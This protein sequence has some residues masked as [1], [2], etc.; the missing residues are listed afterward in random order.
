MLHRLVALLIVTFSFVPARIAQPAPL[1]PPDKIAQI[2]R[3]TNGAARI[4]RH[5]QTGQV[6]FIGG[7]LDRPIAPPPMGMASARPE[8][9]AQ[10]FVQQYGSLFGAPNAADLRVERTTQADRGRAFVRFG[11]T[12]NGVPV[13]G[14]EL[15]VQTDARGATISASGELAPN[16]NLS[17]TP[18][19]TATTAQIRAV[20]EIARQR[21]VPG[22]RLAAAPPQLAIFDAALL[23]GPPLPRPVL[24]WRTEVTSIDGGLREWVLIDALR[25]VVAL[26]FD[27]QAG[28]L[29]RYVCDNG[30]VPR[31]SD[32]C[33]AAGAERSEGGP[34][35]D[36]PQVNRA[37]EYMGVTYE[38]WRS[39][40]NRDSFDGAGA[41]LVATVR[42]CAVNA[43]CPDRKLVAYWNG[44]QAVFVDDAVVDDFVAHELTH[45]LIQHTARLYNYYQ[46]GAISESLADVFGELIDQSY[47]GAFDTDTADVRWLIG[48]DLPSDPSVPNDGAVRNMADPPLLGDPDRMSSPLYKGGEDDYGGI[49]AN[50]GVG[51]KAAVL[52]TDGGTFNGRTIA[53]L[54][55]DKTARIY[56]ETTT[57]LLVSG[58]DYADLAD[59][60][61]QGCTNL[62]GTAAITANDCAAVEGVVTATEMRQS[63]PQAP[64][65]EAPVC[66]TGLP[67][68]LWFDDMENV[69]RNNWRSRSLI[70]GYNGWFYP[71][72]SDPYSN[73]DTNYST[74]GRFN[75]WGD[76]PDR[77]G[78][79]AIAQTF[80]TRLPPNALLHFRHAYWFDDS[81][82]NGTRTFFDGGVVEYSTNGG[83]T[84]QDAGD[85]W[86]H[87]GYN[88]RLTT[89]E[90]NPL[91]GREAFSG[92]SNGYR[93]SRLDLQ[94]LAGE[95]VRFRFRIGSDSQYAYYG[96]F[97]DD[98]RVYTCT[99]NGLSARS[100]MPLAE[101]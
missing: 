40:F 66:E 83:A 89:T 27:Q 14:G 63:P 75:L 96:W 99:Q 17:T 85:L 84:W 92:R 72:T 7:S 3:A 28:A 38:W 25:G 91:E 51:N 71:Q 12:Y 22:A 26:R 73:L 61:A 6:R 42:Q 39:R 62:T 65:P 52:L 32:A 43:S 37:Y 87:N 35:A 29:E 33:S 90:D 59:A 30:N 68:T 64:A 18:T 4:S 56:Y 41:P 78:D 46:S 21:N 93:S 97:I 58:S 13:I 16:L 10:H 95:R 53:G 86:T 82:N 1:N 23:G 50:S 70:S 9:A 47:A 100:Y 57:N 88:A 79:F 54:G 8:A 101:K 69:Q 94:S 19:I 98:V 5:A 77:R 55:P 31:A 36:E 45:G 81:L 24:V 15:I 34:P 76:D 60:L 74:S 20:A 11:Q 2:Q 48:E 67:S 80:D 44:N 49:H